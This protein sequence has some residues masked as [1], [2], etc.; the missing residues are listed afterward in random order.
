MRDLK[1][2]FRVNYISPAQGVAQTEKA[3]GHF[4]Q[5]FQ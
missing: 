2:G 4:R 1:G 3:H 5:L